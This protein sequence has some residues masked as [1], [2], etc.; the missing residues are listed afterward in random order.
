MSYSQGKTVLSAFT[1]LIIFLISVS[2]LVLTAAYNFDLG[3][4]F[5]AVPI[6]MAYTLNAPE[7]SIGK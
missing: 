6:W 3:M 7:W 1:Y 2:I 4:I 5:D